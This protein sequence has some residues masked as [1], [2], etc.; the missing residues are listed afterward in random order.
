MVFGLLGGVVGQFGSIVA[1]RSEYIVV[2]GRA[3]YGWQARTAF[4]KILL[5]PS[6]Q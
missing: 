6:N 3:H 2:V 1:Q 5:V 4:G